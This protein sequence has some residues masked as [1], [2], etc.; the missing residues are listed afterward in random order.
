MVT[1]VNRQ[2]VEEFGVLHP[3]LTIYLPSVAKLCPAKADGPSLRQGRWH[4]LQGLGITAA[5]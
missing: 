3:K 5:W 4:A 2:L 1:N